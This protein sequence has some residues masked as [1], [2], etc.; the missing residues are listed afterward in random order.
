MTYLVEKGKYI[1][2]KSR[3]HFGEELSGTNEHMITKT[4]VQ[5]T[6]GTHSFAC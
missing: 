6:T 3:K 4:Q 2:L 1:K 5:S